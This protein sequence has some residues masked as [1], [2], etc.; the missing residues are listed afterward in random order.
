M[1]GCLAKL[2]GKFLISGDASVKAYKSICKAHKVRGTSVEADSV[3][4]STV[5]A[6]VVIEYDFARKLSI[7]T[8]LFIGID[9]SSKGDGRSFVEIEFGVKL[10]HGELQT[11]PVVREI[12]RHKAEDMLGMKYNKREINK[13]NYKLIKL[14]EEI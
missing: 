7:G 2:R 5:E 13:N 3:I 1:R 10:P 6:G 12:V 14:N 11:I 9:E 4:R 8:D